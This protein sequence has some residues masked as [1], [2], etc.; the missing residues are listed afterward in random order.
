VISHKAAPQHKGDKAV[1]FWA[2][3]KEIVNK[4]RRREVGDQIV[5]GIGDQYATCFHPSAS[6]RRTSCLCDGNIGNDHIRETT[7]RKSSDLSIT[8]RLSKCRNTAD[9]ASKTS[10]SFSI[11]AHHHQLT[12]V[13]DARF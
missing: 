1:S 9:I 7:L 8:L 2:M 6:S 3:E 5:V 10:F 12:R 13:L 11:D 4:G